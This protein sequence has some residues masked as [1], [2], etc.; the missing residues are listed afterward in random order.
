MSVPRKAAQHIH[1]EPRELD[2]SFIEPEQLDHKITQWTS[3]SA[4][5]NR[6]LD[7]AKWTDRTLTMVDLFS[8]VITDGSMQV[9]QQM[10]Q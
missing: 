5:W 6:T 4:S 7:Y 2:F 8:I 1:Y 3:T 10:T 9:E